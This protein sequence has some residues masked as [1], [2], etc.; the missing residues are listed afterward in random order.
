MKYSFQDL[1]LYIPFSQ[2]TFLTSLPKE[3]VYY[4]SI[5]DHVP[6]GAFER[7]TLMI[8]ENSDEWDKLTEKTTI[9]RLIQERNFMGLVICAPYAVGIPKEICELCQEFELPIVQ[10]FDSSLKYI[11]QQT[12][13]FLHPFSQ[14]SVELS[15]FMEKGFAHL[16]NQLSKALNIPILYF[17]QNDQLIWKTDDRNDY[18]EAIRSFNMNLRKVKN[19]TDSKPTMEIGE[20]FQVYFIQ[21]SEYVV[22]SLVVSSQL[23]DWQ[24]KMIDKLVGLTAISLQNQETFLEHQEVFKE[25][26]VYDLLYHKFESKKVMV[27]QGKVW[28]WNLERPHHLL[29]LDIEINQKLMAD[30]DWLNDIVFH[31]EAEAT[32]LQEKIIVFRFQDQIII[33][34]EDTKEMMSSERKS[35]VLQIAN[36]IEEKLSNKWTNTQFNIGIGKWYKDTTNL[37][38]CYQEAKLSL[39][40]GKDW[41]GNDKRVFHINNLGIL[42]LLIHIHHELLVDF[43]QEYLS[44]LIDSDQ[45]TATEYVKTLE[46]YI[47]YH[48]KVN[49]VSDALYVHP[50]TLRKRL[51]KIEEITG[52]QL[53]DSDDLMTLTIAVRIMSLLQ[54]K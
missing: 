15:G 21:I 10:I 41:F 2:L 42:S 51:R 38:K 50:N 34:L 24:K 44:A 16:T 26:F 33:L 32:K 30:L 14:I 27:K 12:N 47:R 54:Y 49:E 7:S 1:L 43:S 45:E 29:L 28:G 23:H 6:E 46:M 31:L 25:H 48:E 17:D 13:E 4:E 35:Y 52:M 11:F 8:L 37:N 19:R 40:F 22:H 9:I 5:L 39:K 18:V 36:H 3:L 20:D 53:Q